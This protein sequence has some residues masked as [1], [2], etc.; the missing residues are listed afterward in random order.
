MKRIAGTVAAALVSAFLLAK[1]QSVWWLAGF[2]L[3]PCLVTVRAAGR[4][5]AVFLG[6]GVGTLAACLALSWIPEALRALGASPERAL[7]GLLVTA[8][9]GKAP[10]FAVVGLVARELRQASALVQVGVVGTVLGAGEWLLATQSWGLPGVL[11]GHSQIGAL[12]VAQLAVIG[13]VPLLSA[14]LVSLNAAIALVLVGD[15]HARALAAALAVS[16]LVTAGLG[17]RTASALRPAPSGARAVD[18]LLVQPAIPR[19]ARWDRSAQ[20]WILERVAAY[21]TEALSAQAGP[22]DAIVWPE[23]LL[24]TPI[25]VD[26]E[27]ES[28]LQRHV[29]TWGV[30]LISGFTR[31]PKVARQ[32]RYRSSVG[33]I[34]PRRGLVAAMDKERAVPLLE[35]S[36]AV[37]GAS[38]LA[39]LFG[40]AARW[41]KV[42]EGARAVGSS[43]AASRSSPP[44]ATRCSS[45]AS[46]PAVGR[47]RPLPSSTSPTTAGPLGRPPPA[48]SAP[49][50]RSAPS[51]SA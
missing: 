9:W 7:S 24:T 30:P 11:V 22:V 50:P 46:S 35:S 18:L 29:D 32:G 31:A 17:L 1:S 40:R 2:A 28:A 45:R 14:W 16:W 51:S 26:P 43:E 8:A 33:W 38:L 3:V 4:L 27:L 13:S 25:D 10:L 34:E 5:E 47:P 39:P 20:P 23:N 48:S 12:G 42:E 49:G 36:R 41:P 44:S 21:T 15:R 19:H 6:A 37:P